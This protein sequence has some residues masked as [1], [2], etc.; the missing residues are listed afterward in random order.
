VISQPLSFTLAAGCGTDTAIRR[1]IPHPFVPYIPILSTR[2]ASPT[3]A[4]FPAL[5]R[6]HRRHFS[7]PNRGTYRTIPIDTPARPSY[8]RV[9]VAI[10]A[11]MYPRIVST[12]LDD[13]I[14]KI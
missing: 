6:A 4:L 2:S 12:D 14:G 11:L 8:T 10:W 7:Y 1:I 13:L 5:S 9:Q 3:S